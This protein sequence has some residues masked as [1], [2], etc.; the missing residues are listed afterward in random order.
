MVAALN[1]SL[2][3]TMTDQPVPAA[4]APVETPAEAPP[5]PADAAPPDAAPDAPPEEASEEAPPINDDEIKAR[6]DLKEQQDKAKD[7]RLALLQVKYG[8]S[9]E[10]MA[11]WKANFGRISSVHIAGQLYIYRGLFRLEFQQLMQSSDVR[12]MIESG[13]EGADKARALNEKRI[14]NRGVLFPEV[15]GKAWDKDLAGIL[16]TLSDLILNFSGFVPDDVPVEL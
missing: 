8:I 15:K 11:G 5:P 14:T 10:Q 4:E 12:E 7:A 13:P 2:E 6:E 9:P 3:I 1:S 16:N